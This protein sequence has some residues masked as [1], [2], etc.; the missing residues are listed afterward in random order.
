MTEIEAE[1]VGEDNNAIEIRQQPAVNLFRVA[2]ETEV[3]ERA[4]AVAD[5]VRPII[6]QRGWAKKFGRGDREH[7]EIQGWQTVGGMVGVHAVITRTERITDD[8]G[9]TGWEARAE[10]RTMSGVIVGT[11]DSQCSRSEA[12][13]KSKDDFS[14]RS[15][16]QTRACSRALQA[17]LRWVIEL[18]GFA[19]TPAEEMDYGQA[20][21]EE[22]DGGPSCPTCNS[23]VWDNSADPNRGKR[24]KWKC[25]DKSCGWASWDDDPFTSQGSETQ[26]SEPSAA[27][28]A[29]PHPGPDAAAAPEVV[30]AGDG[31]G[32]VAAPVAN[33][34]VAHIRAYVGTGEGQK[35]RRKQVLA[36][37]NRV[38]LAEEQTALIPTTGLTPTAVTALPTE[39]VTKIAAALPVEEPEG[40]A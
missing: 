30:A 15:M 25:K 16:A 12:N 38:L 18:A 33:D 17:P 6:K 13:W 4:L 1:I 27:D 39:L 10:A 37:A 23:S 32:E 3:I 14:L 19:G 31:G 20:V 9:A 11:A 36:I 2:D 22:H 7:V 34:P 40:W 5:K 8:Q 28:S 35:K 21:A 24:P 29:T 26:T